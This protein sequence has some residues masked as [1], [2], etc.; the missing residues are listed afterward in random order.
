[1]ASSLLASYPRRYAWAELIKRVFLEDLLQCECG[2][3]REVIALITE[4]SVIGPILTCLGLASEAPTVERARPPPPEQSLTEP[5]P[6]H[7]ET[8]VD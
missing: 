2:A 3:R 6:P 8:W 4:P 5:E 7:T 1:M